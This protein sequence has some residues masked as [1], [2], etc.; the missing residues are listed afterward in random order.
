MAELEIGLIYAYSPQAKGRIE[1]SIRTFQD[2]LVKE[3]A[4]KEISDPEKAT[5]YTNEVFI[6]RYNRKFAVEA[7]EKEKAWRKPPKNLKEILSRRMSRKVKADLT[8]SVEGRVLQLKLPRLTM[9]LSGT[10]VEVRELF[11]GSFRVYHNAG[12][13]IPHEEIKRDKRS[14]RKKIFRIKKKTYQ[15]GDIFPLQ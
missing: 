3:L 14:C 9:R 1:R 2:R 10:R 13:I 5:L 4:L 8:I 7:E 12:E 15:G 11:D 6:P